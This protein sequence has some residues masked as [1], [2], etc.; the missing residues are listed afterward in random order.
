MSDLLNYYHTLPR[1]SSSAMDRSQY[2]T[3]HG[4]MSMHSPAP[5]YTDCAVRRTKSSMPIRIMRHITNKARKDLDPSTIPVVSRREQ[6]KA[7][8][9]EQ[10]KL[11]ECQAQQR[12][13]YHEM[14][15]SRQLELE[16]SAIAAGQ[17]QPQKK[18]TVR[19]KVRDTLRRSGTSIERRNA[20]GNILHNHPDLV[21]P[22]PVHPPHIDT[23]GSKDELRNWFHPSDVEGG[24]AGSSC[25]ANFY[26][27]E[28]PAAEISSP[29]ASSSKSFL[30]KELEE[31]LDI[32]ALPPPIRSPSPCLS[33][34]P[35]RGITISQSPKPIA[36][37]L[38]HLPKQMQC[39]Y[40]HGAIKMTGFHYACIVCNDGDC[41]YC[42]NC[43]Q[44]GRTCRHEL[45]ERTRD[46]KRHPTN[47]QKGERKSFVQDKDKNSVTS[48]DLNA[49]SI[50]LSAFPGSMT[51]CQ[52]ASSEILLSKGK[53]P[54]QS[55]PTSIHTAEDLFRDF[56]AKRREQEIAFREKEVT[57]REREAMLREREA[58]TLSKEREATFI[59]QLHASSVR[60]QRVEVGSQF[61]SCTPT[62]R[63]S[64]FGHRPSRHGSQ[65]SL[66]RQPF[67]GVPSSE[68]ATLYSGEC[69][70]KPNIESAS[71][72]VNMTA[73]VGGIEDAATSVRSH[74][75]G[76]KR[77]SS[78]AGTPINRST[79]RKAQA[80]GRRISQRRNVDE[81]ED[82]GEQ[83]SESDA[84]SPKRR[85][86]EASPEPQKLFACPYFKHDPVRYAEGNT[87]ELNYR[88]CAGGL[89]RDISRVKQHLKRI[90][91]YPE[92]YCR[93][94]FA[95]F[96]TND[97]LQKHSSLREAC[98]RRDCPYPERI[99]ETKQAKIHVKRPGKNPKE[100]WLEIYSIIFP[101]SPQPDS[102]Y[103]EHLQQKPA[104]L[105]ALDQFIEL[106]RRRLDIAAHSQPWLAPESSSRDFLD[107]QLRQAVQDL[108]IVVGSGG[109]S[110]VL[111][112]PTSSRNDSLSHL[113]SR[114]SRES[115]LLSY[116]APTASPAPA[117]DIRPALKVSTSYGARSVAVPTAG[118]SVRRR[119]DSTFPHIA[120]HI[121]EDSGYGPE[122]ESWASG[123]DVRLMFNAPTLEPSSATSTRSTKSVSFAPAPDEWTEFTNLGPNTSHFT[124]YQH[125]SHDAAL[126]SQYSSMSSMTSHKAT[127]QHKRADSA[128]GTMSSAQASENS[129]IQPQPQFLSTSLTE[130]GW[131]SSMDFA[132]Y[133]HQQQHQRQHQQ[134]PTPYADPPVLFINPA[135][136]NVP[137]SPGVS[138]D[139]QAYLNR[140]MS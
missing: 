1:H 133:P 53:E 31:P 18:S 89:Y 127:S 32:D 107:I 98:E 77:K 88:G 26:P 117:P 123:D 110:S 80:Q 43:A 28:L 137:V 48:T 128:Y 120:C 94:C 4:R 66:P 52:P 17:L 97:K 104:Q 90:H 68:A 132:T 37:P 19:Q 87:T 85:K 3:M 56:E 22:A 64:S 44:E 130:Q 46:I 83:S 16:Q 34:V 73:S 96:D 122:G 81:L 63:H 101:Q 12:K 7:E 38:T 105:P 23:F 51:D 14:A 55:S 126:A 82:D 13:Q 24:P 102:P 2:G 60:Q 33:S 140:N 59:Q 116:R 115:S 11:E 135:D 71:Y 69:A 40:C 50:E 112:S 114:S 92:F 57:L 74:G 124:P 39:D 125:I 99:N 138:A 8:K 119:R 62:S 5:A 134:Q 27:A 95:L 15:R 84:S 131:P 35:R 49:R 75:S 72:H 78:N 136:L 79:S 93:R 106:F 111:I 113:S 65:R 103:I 108:E 61:Q 70:K 86:H 20:R 36:T 42:A 9:R 6:R 91:H 76:D 30:K 58:W 29:F 100:L 10:R 139:L 121:R 25:I 54:L 21:E 47:P 109:V 45:I 129:L 118:D 41:L 67:Q